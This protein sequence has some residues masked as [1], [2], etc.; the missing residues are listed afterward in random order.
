MHGKQKILVVH[1]VFFVSNSGS[2][3]FP[4]E[5]YASTFFLLPV[6]PYLASRFLSQAQATLAPL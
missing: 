3:A 1:I 6:S 2:I 4:L 5:I